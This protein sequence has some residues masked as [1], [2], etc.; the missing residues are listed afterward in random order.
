MRRREFILAL[1]G[2]ICTIPA[3]AKA[4]QIK[5][6]AIGFLDSGFANGMDAYLAGFRH[7]MKEIG[8]V[9]GDNVTMLY[10]WAEG[11]MD[12]L[13]TFAAELAS[14]PVDL[15]VGSRGP[16]PG[17]AAKTAT[18][19][20]PVVFQTGSDPVEIGLVASM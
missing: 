14:R 2:A 20:I 16:A 15:I 4:Q 6:P 5:L 19:S 3:A 10:R 17:L 7:R 8:Y 11:R 9:E 13:K 18:S 1:G 12:Q